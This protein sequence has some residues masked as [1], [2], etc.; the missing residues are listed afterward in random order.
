[1]IDSIDCGKKAYHDKK[2]AQTVANSRKTRKAGRNNSRRGRAKHLRAYQC[3]T[4]GGWHLSSM[5]I[6]AQ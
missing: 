1:M 5:R 4:C 3:P 2:T 6:Y